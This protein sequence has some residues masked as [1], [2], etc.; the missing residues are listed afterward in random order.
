MSKT[1]LTSFL[2]ALATIVLIA[3]IIAPP[4]LR[5][6]SERQRSEAF[7]A[8]VQPVLDRLIDAERAHKEREGKF[9]RDQHDTLSPEATKQALGMDLGATPGYR[10]EVYPADLVADP[11]LRV[12][13]KGTGENEG[14]LME[15]VYD[16]IQHTKS[17]KLS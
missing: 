13:A 10:V 6:R 3:A 4:Y 12:A 1:A 7:S 15:C 17:C 2:I 5:A 16:A 9:W 8:R 14:L 11:T